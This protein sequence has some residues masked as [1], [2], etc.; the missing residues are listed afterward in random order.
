[1]KSIATFALLSLFVSSAFLTAGNAFGQSGQI[2][3]GTLAI[4]GYGGL[5]F[6][7][8]NVESD[9][10]NLSIK[11]STPYV[12][13][14]GEEF[15]AWLVDDSRRG[16]GY[17]LS[18]GAINEDGTLNYTGHLINAYTYTHIQITTEPKNDLDPK[19]AWSNT[20]GIT[21]LVPPFG[22]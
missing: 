1:M 14:K 7:L 2:K 13:P 18:L 8:A 9:G 22:Q 4:V 20:V 21:K 15:E 3:Q 5:V 12:P 6:G 17:S 16:S 19:A 11:I 10:K